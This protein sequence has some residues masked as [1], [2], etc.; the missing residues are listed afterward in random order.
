[1]S[2][3]VKYRGLCSSC[4]NAPDCT[5]PREPNRPVLQCEEFDGGE[6]SPT[7]TVV[8]DRVP[9]T[10][11][12]TTESKDST[13]FMGLCSNCE[14]RETCTYPKLEGGVWHCEEYR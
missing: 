2:Q 9:S 1:M 11:S 7:K 3:N 14:D 8:K 4:E 10:R 13:K 6:P 5:Y 12:Y